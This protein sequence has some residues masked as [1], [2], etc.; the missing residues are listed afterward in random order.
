MNEFYERKVGRGSNFN[1]DLYPLINNFSFYDLIDK[2]KDSN[3]NLEDYGAVIVITD[4]QYIIGY[5]AGY[6]A[7]THNSAYARIMKELLGGGEISNLSDAEVLCDKCRK[8]YLTAR[9]YYSRLIT[10][11]GSDDSF[12]GTIEFDL[13]NNNVTPEKF[14]MFK[15]LYDQYNSELLS[16]ALKRNKFSVIYYYKEND[17][18]M[19]NET[20]SL[21]SLY[22]YLEDHLINTTNNDNELIIG[23]SK[24]KVIK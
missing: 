11:Y 2:S 19:K 17:R 4:K 15:L 22:L 13:T 5:T 3:S 10:N 21:D 16:L 1:Y 20:N 12:T 6:G 8:Q 18:V 24:S 14:E 9:I 7:G 23:T